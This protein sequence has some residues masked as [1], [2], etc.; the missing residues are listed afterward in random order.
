[1]ARTRGIDRHPPSQRK[2]G[3]SFVN[4]KATPEYMAWSSM[5]ARCLRPTANNYPLYGG[6]GIT[7]CQRWTDNFEA[8]LSDMGLK[9]SKD[10][11][12]DRI[13]NDGNYEPGNCRWAT[14]IMQSRNKRNVGIVEYYGERLTVPELSERVGIPLHRLKSRLKRG[15]SIER[16][17]K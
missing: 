9:P 3:H 17:T 7:I 8:F 1:M 12:L 5:K 4:G 2:H 6:R 13:D 15:W 10:H 14:P 11:S 16:A